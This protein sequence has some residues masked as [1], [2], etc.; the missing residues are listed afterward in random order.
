MDPQQPEPVSYLCGGDLPLS[1]YPDCLLAVYLLARLGFSRLVG[2]L[3]LIPFAE[4][5]QKHNTH[6]R[7]CFVDLNSFLSQ[8]IR[9]TVEFAVCWISRC[10]CCT[11][12][13]LSPSYFNEYVLQ[14]AELRTR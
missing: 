10:W 5:E 8:T 9:G 1:I 3:V 2:H 14:I 7:S 6:A 13:W 4:H 12:S 11:D